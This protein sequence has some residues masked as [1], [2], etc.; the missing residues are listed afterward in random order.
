MKYQTTMLL[1]HCVMASALF[2]SPLF[3]AAQSGSDEDEN[4][5]ISN[6]S[7]EEVQ[8]KLKR[9]GNIDQAT[10]WS[11]PTNTKAD[12]F[13]ET[14]PGAPISAPR[15][16]YGDQ[17]A[18]DGINYA[19]VRW[20]S[21]QNKQPRSYLQAKLKKMMKKDQKYCVKFYVSLADLSKYATNELGAYLSKIPIKKGDEMSL[22]YNA[23]VPHL[24]DKVQNDLY[25]WQGVCGVYEAKGDEQYLIIG[26]FAATEKTLNEKV[27]RPKGESR[28]QLTHAYYYI[29]KVSVTPIERA[30]ECTCEQVDKAESEFIFSRKGVLSPNLK[31][32]ERADARVIY[33]K[34]FQR[35]IDRSMEPWIDELVED[36]KADPSL[37]VKLTGH[38]D[39]T[40]KDRTRMRPDLETLGLERAETVKEALVEAGIDAGRIT[41]AGATEDDPADTSGSEVGMSKNRRV[42]VDVE[43]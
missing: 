16:Q 26:N 13:S 21:F 41:V 37:K 20:W 22:T 17:S 12:L 2:L 1:R 31:P 7:F 35:S 15:N 4:N 10:G 30:S 32:A 42:E 9:P 36:L 34:R 24:R 28:P 11:S 29:D 43:K 19:G 14:V 23:Q 33:F 8:G 25:S 18:L 3:L 38:I 5:L 40:E 6:G 39:E 27:K